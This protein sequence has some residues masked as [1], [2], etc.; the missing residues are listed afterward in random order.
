MEGG[1]DRPSSEPSENQSRDGLSAR[2]GG[3]GSAGFGGVWQVGLGA[4]GL[5]DG[6]A[7]PWA[8]IGSGRR[9]DN[10]AGQTAA[11]VQPVPAPCI[12]RPGSMAAQSGPAGPLSG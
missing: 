6:F 3:G 8:H 11:S 2:G 9:A 4:G 5:W 10:E 1:A 7:T 12:S